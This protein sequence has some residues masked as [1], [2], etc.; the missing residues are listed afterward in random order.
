VRLNPLSWSR[1]PHRHYW[2]DDARRHHR[3][4]YGSDRRGRHRRL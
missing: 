1:G 4:G 2:P 3:F